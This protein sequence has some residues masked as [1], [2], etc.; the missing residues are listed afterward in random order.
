MY[1][2]PDIHKYGHNMRHNLTYYGHFIST[3]TLF[4]IWTIYTHNIC[5]F[6]FL[7]GSLTITT[8]LINFN[9][10]L[11]PKMI[12]RSV[13]ILRQYRRITQTGRLFPVR[14]VCVHPL[15]TVSSRFDVPLPEDALPYLRRTRDDIAL[16]GGNLHVIGGGFILRSRQAEEGAWC[17]AVY[18][19]WSV[20][21]WPV[22]FLWTTLN[23][24]S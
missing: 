24:S 16:R 5:L 17:D 21:P 19:I 7:N 18:V 1:V 4:Y 12:C 3:C 13:S 14:S 9:L 15:H 20:P 2:F 10:N 23:G 6:V 11:P 8:S 22:Y